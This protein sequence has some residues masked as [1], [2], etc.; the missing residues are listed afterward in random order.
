MLGTSP[1][2]KAVLCVVLRTKGKLVTAFFLPP[3]RSAHLPDC[4]SPGWY[5]LDQGARIREGT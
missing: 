3:A 5:S 4:W 1:F 2:S